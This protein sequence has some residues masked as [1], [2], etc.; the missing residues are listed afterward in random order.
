MADPTP[1]PKPDLEQR[2]LASV[3]A[4]EGWFKT[5]RAWLIAVAVALA[6]GFIVGHLV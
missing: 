6:L 4:G 3:N 1:A 2:A 5:N